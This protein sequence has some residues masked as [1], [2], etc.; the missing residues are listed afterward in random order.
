MQQPSYAY[1]QQ[2]NNQTEYSM[3]GQRG[4]SYP[5]PPPAYAPPALHPSYYVQQPPQVAQARIGVA[6]D[7]S[8]LQASAPPLD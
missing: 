5:P 1:Y 2:F 4:I 3:Q 6:F 8:L 7:G